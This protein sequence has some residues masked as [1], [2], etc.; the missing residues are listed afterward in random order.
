MRPRRVRSKATVNASVLRMSKSKKMNK[1]LIISCI[2]ISVLCGVSIIAVSGDSPSVPSSIS[3]V[4]LTVA[5]PSQPIQLPRP[6]PGVYTAAPF[7]MVVVV[8]EPVD[9]QMTVAIRDTSLF[10]TPCIRPKTRLERR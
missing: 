3:P 7:S 10:R 5:V 9:P 6:S 8:P 2:A 1:P 4:L